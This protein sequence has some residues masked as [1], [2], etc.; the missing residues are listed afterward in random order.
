MVF[1]IW[2]PAA[3]NLLHVTLVVPRIFMV[4]SRIL[5]NFC[6]PRLRSEIRSCT[7]KGRL[8]LAECHLLGM[9]TVCFA[10][11][12]LHVAT[13]VQVELNLHTGRSLAES[14]IPDAVLIQFDL[15]MMSTVFLETCRGL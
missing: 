5:E 13:G 10:K 2:R 8:K 11:I 6:I 1:N 9:L 7:A 4:A 3:H 12:H 15:L 14:T